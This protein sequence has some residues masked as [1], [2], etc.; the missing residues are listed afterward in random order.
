MEKGAFSDTYDPILYFYS[1]LIFGLRR[2]AA[3]GLLH[4]E[5]PQ[6]GCKQAV[7]FAA[8]GNPKTLHRGHPRE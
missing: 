1:F 6:K 4:G 7:A 8:A 2:F 5:D 3:A